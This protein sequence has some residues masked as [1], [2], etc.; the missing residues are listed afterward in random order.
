MG[1]K[2]IEYDIPVYQMWNTQI[3]KYTNT[4]IRK[5][6]NTRCLTDPTSAIYFSNSKCFKDPTYAIF[7][8]IIG[9]KDI[10]YDIPMYQI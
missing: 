1:F 3:H 9:F 4:Q 2:D 5:Y 8:K 6:T 10:K 7:L